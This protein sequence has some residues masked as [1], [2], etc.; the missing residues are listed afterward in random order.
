[1]QL[2]SDN[3][4]STLRARFHA[5]L[6]P[7]YGV[8]ETDSMFFILCGEYL[9]KKR[10]EVILDHS[11]RLSESELLKFHYALKDLIRHRPLQYILGKAPFAGFDFFVEE[12][13]LIP[14]PETEE[15][16]HHIISENASREN[17]KILDIGTG[18]GCI[19][20]SL[21]RLLPDSEVH[22]IDVS[23]KALRIAQKNQQQ[24]LS[25]VHFH[26]GDILAASTRFPENYFDVIVSN[27][28]YIAIAEK[29][30]M[31]P[32]VLNFEP[33]EA[34]FV[35]DNDALLFYKIIENKAAGWLKEKG[36]LW[37]EINEHL[38]AETLQL[39]HNQKWSESVIIND[40]QGKERMIRVRK[41]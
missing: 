12:G 15:L 17:I 33:S 18:S 13:V 41:A 40:F 21:Q 20:I 2:P 6:D 14:R 38:G 3:H 9:N 8:S 36:Q 37:L 27:P 4:L 28:P 11:L 19:A 1:M 35:P 32:N 31:H 24:L 5:L 34:L 23:E 39:F 16:V 22:A 25:N 29:E 7:D 26:Q 30:S 10:S